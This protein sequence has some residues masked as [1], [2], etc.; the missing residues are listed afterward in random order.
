MKTH[1]LLLAIL[2]GLMIQLPSLL[3]ATDTRVETLGASGVFLED[4]SNI[5]NHPSALLRYTNQLVLGLG[6][7]SSILT[8]ASELATLGTFALPRGM[9]LG[10]GFGSAERD[11]TFAPLNAEEQVH[12]FWGI[13]RGERRY[14]LRLSRFGTIRDAPPQFERSV[15]ITQCYIGLE[16]M[17]SADRRFEV[18]ILA[19]DTRFAEIRNGDTDSESTAYWK[20]GLHS[21]LVTTLTENV[22]LVPVLEVT[23]G[24]R[25]TD[26]YTDGAISETREEGYYVAQAGVA[27]ELTSADD[28]LVILHV[29]TKVDYLQETTSLSSEESG[30]TIWDI[31]WVGLGLERW[32]NAWLAIRVGAGLRLRLEDSK[33]SGAS[34][35]LKEVHTLTAHTLGLAMQY[36]GFQVDFA[37]DPTYLKRGPHFI[38]GTSMPLFGKATL[39]YRF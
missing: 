16:S 30:M 4:E 3:T 25:G 1:T 7:Q 33:E 8:P 14:G 27:F 6:G 2:I 35:S 9:A 34:N 24:H 31:A 18:T 22:R 19:E 17:M 32:V 13:S 10:L 26:L 15:G 36:G 23:V 20:L 11:V 5:W 28:L 12:L 21:R 39:T 29:S 38:S 37:I